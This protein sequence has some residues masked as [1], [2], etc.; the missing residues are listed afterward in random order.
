MVH[1]FI[2]IQLTHV[3]NAR[4]FYGGVL[5]CIEGR[6]SPGK[7]VDFS[8]NGH[9]IVCHWVGNEYNAVDYYNPVDGDEV[10]GANSFYQIC[11]AFVVRS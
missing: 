3:F 9:Q 7:W 8:L 2:L 6:S 11:F 4:K 1:H 5:G 10:P